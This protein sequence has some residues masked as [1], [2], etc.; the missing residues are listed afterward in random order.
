LHGDKLKHE[1][2]LSFFA[3]LK[4]T[5]GFVIIKP[6][7]KSNLKLLGILKG[8]KPFARSWPHL[9]A[10]SWRF[11]TSALLLCLKIKILI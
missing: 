6:G 10:R 3:Q 4:N 2:Q 8:F 1:E 11:Y 7:I 5:F 9:Y